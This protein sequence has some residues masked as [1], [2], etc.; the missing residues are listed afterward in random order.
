MTARSGLA[1]AGIYLGLAARGESRDLG[2]EDH[3]VVYGARPGG[4]AVV[5]IRGRQDIP[6][7]NQEVREGGPDGLQTSLQGARRPDPEHQPHQQPQVEP[8]HVDQQPLQDVGVASQVG[9][10]HA[11]GLVQVSEG[12]L[13]QFAAGA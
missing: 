13:Q 2:G 10:P 7:G 5:A 11:A 6:E 12:P 3:V 1:F 9:A 4:G 8:A